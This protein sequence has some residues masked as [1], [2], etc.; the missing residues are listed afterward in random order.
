MGKKHYI[1]KRALLR[2]SPLIPPKLYLR[3]LFRATIGHRLDLDHPKSFN[4]KMQW[5]KIHDRNPLYPRLVDKYRVKQYV[6]EKIG[7][8]YTIDTLGAW[9]SP[10]AIDFDSLPQSFVLKTTHGGGA[11]GVIICKD[12]TAMD[13]SIILSKLGASMKQDIAG[14]FLEWPYSQIKPGIIAEPLMFQHDGGELIDYKIHCFNGI[15]RFILVCSGR[16]SE[17]G[18]KDDF[19]DMN[20]KRINCARPAHP[21]SKELPSAPG[22]LSRMV[23]IAESLSAGFPFLRVDFYE[24]NDRVFVGELTLY[25]ASGFSRFI[26]EEMDYRFGEYLSLSSVQ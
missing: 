12:K 10:D 20:W 9:D 6:E 15:P 7:P 13:K 4:E 17:D 5:L 26:P 8:G 23:E 22:Q 18:L 2:L 11:C 25:P 3:L 16:F 14:K 1:F 19:V 24:I 21:N